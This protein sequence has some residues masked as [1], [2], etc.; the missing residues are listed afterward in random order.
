MTIKKEMLSYDIM[1]LLLRYGRS[2]IIGELAIQLDLSEER[3]RVELERMKDLHN[4]TV[5]KK[6]SG[7]KFSVKQL[8]SKHPEIADVL[9]ILDARYENRTFMP[10]LKDVKKFLDQNG[11]ASRTV[12]SRQVAKKRVFEVLLRLEPKRLEDLAAEEDQTSGSSLG[13]ISDQILR[14]W[15]NSE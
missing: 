8:A 14:R 3:L 2:A 12:K 1:L 15:K 10:E 7:A 4:K 5:V 6:R 13:I 11:H 9:L